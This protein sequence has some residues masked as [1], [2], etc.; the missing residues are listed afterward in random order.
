VAIPLVLRDRIRLRTDAVDRVVLGKLK[1]AFEHA[2]PQYV[3]KKRIDKGWWA[4]ESII[5]TWRETLDGVLEIPRGGLQRVRN[6]LWEAGLDWEV[7]DERTEGSGPKGEIPKHQPPGGGALWMP[8]ADLLRAGVEGQNCILRSATGTG[9]TTTLLATAAFINL[10]T[11]VVV[12][13]SGLFKQWRERAQLELPGLGR[14]GVGYI[15]EGG[16]DLA[17]VT[18]ALQASLV[19]AMKNERV[20]A[21]ILD[22]FGVL[23]ADEVQYAPARTFFETFDSFPAKYRIG[24]S[25]SER[26]KDR[27]EFLA[28]DLFGPV[29]YEY[30]REQAVGDGIIIEVEMRVI[31]TDFRAA[32]YGLLTRDEEKQLKQSKIDPSVAPPPEKDL[33]PTRLYK[34][35]AGDPDR[36]L[37]LLT[38]LVREAGAGSICIALA[39]HVEHVQRFAQRLTAAGLK[40]GLLLGGKENGDEFD[41]TKKLLASGDIQVAVGTYKA[42]GTGID[43]PRVDVVACLTPIAANEQEVNQVRGRACRRGKASARMY[44]LWDQHVYPRHLPNLARW[45]PGALVKHGNDWIPAKKRRH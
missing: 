44:Y 28:N 43:I 1:A 38:E 20:R 37:L 36:D 4:E 17:P 5:T 10:P 12:P 14:D 35:M 16:V 19:A 33:D 41:R 22:Y 11:I 18:I 29:A 3:L 9:K 13:T 6:V 32:W 15:Y 27:K 24:M 21:E 7:V 30:T 8:Q 39:H 31:P 26:R 40:T 45:C 34:E 2:N 25:A 23:L 42:T